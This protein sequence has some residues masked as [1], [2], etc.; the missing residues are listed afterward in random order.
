MGFNLKE[1]GRRQESLTN[2]SS[3]PPIQIRSHDQ[4]TI[5]EEEEVPASFFFLMIRKRW[6]RAL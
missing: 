1:L 2:S 4:K 5:H 3:R 6:I